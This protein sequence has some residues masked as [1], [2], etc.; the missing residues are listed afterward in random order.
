V[1]RL[2]EYHKNVWNG[3][4]PTVEVEGWRQ[5]KSWWSCSWNTGPKNQDKEFEKWN[6]KLGSRVHGHGAILCEQNSWQR[7]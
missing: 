2:L 7:V 4:P 6:R 3:S 5:M 1:G